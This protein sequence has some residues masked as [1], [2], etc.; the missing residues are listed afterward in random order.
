MPTKQPL[1]IDVPYKRAC[2]L[3]AVIDTMGVG[4]F[5]I[6]GKVLR[7]LTLGSKYV[8]ISVLQGSP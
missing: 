8:S 3:V 6:R 7:V 4:V 2:I 5:N 1:M